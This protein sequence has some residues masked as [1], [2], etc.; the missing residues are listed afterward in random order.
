MTGAIDVSMG[1][2]EEPWVQEIGERA[3]LPEPRAAQ[4]DG[5]EEDDDEGDLIDDEDDLDDEDEEEDRPVR[6]ASGEAGVT[7]PR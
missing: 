3:A 7:A 4:E 2:R 5:D 1:G 6:T